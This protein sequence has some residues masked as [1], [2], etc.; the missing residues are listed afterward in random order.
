M[1]GPLVL[2]RPT[3]VSKYCHDFPVLVVIVFYARW[4]ALPGLSVFK[5]NNSG[6]S[7]YDTLNGYYLIFVDVSDTLSNYDKYQIPEPH[8]K[9]TL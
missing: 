3:R 2:P 7:G 5:F 9:Y 6:L 1:E 4:L 8:D